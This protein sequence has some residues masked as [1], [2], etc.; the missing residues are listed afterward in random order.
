MITHLNNQGMICIAI[1]SNDEICQFK[2]YFFKK[3]YGDSKRER[4]FDELCDLVKNMGV[5]YKTHVV[6]SKLNIADC[7]L[8]NKEGKQ[9]IEFLLRIPYSDLSDVIKK[10]IKQYLEINQ[11]DNYLTHQDGFIWIST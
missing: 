9:L 6:K 1:R 4:N 5:K 8:D 3:L 7:L 10:E 2:D 11:H